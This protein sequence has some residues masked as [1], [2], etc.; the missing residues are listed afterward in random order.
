MRAQ[1]EY[2]IFTEDASL[3]LLHYSAKKSKMTNNSN[4]EGPALNLEKRYVA[5]V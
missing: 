1:K 4:Q 2:E 5:P 3:L